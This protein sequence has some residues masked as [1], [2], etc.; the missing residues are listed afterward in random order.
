MAQNFSK[1]I[2]ALRDVARQLEAAFH[3]HVAQA[4]GSNFKPKQ[5]G[6]ATIIRGQ[7]GG[8]VP[9]VRNVSAIKAAL[10]QGNTLGTVA[11]PEGT[12]V[13][14]AQKGLHMVRGP[15]EGWAVF[16][17]VPTKQGSQLH[18]IS[19][20]A[21][22]GDSKA[23][24]ES[25]EELAKARGVPLVRGVTELTNEGKASIARSVAKGFFAAAPE[26]GAPFR[27]IS[28]ASK[29]GMAQLAEN[30]ID[31]LRGVGPLAKGAVKALGSE[32]LGALSFLPDPN[33]MMKVLG[34][35]VTGGPGPGAKHGG[36]IRPIRKR[37][38]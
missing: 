4:R 7:G 28:T 6:G 31:K 23:I 36:K 38:Y 32:A 35:D 34:Y 19:I 12:M 9:D 17:E 25:A 26:T 21:P 20:N 5:P 18:L 37:T 16:A 3:E 8:L 33:L 13:D 11:L 15:K 30:L 24:L 2:Q 1:H 22:G 29:E 14:Y 10:A 27:A